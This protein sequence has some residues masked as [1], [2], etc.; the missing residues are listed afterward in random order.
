MTLLSSLQEELAKP[1]TTVQLCLL[2]IIAG[3]CSASLIILFRLGYESIQLHFLSGVGQYA[4]LA[5]KWRFLLPIAGAILIVI[6]AY[7]TGFKHYRLGIPFII[8]RV[9][10]FYGTVPL[11][12]TLNQFFGGMVALA[13]GFSVGREGPSVH[14]GAAGSSFLGT[15]LK[16]PYN[17]VRILA[18][19]G[20]AAG[21]SASFNTPFAAVIFVMEVVLREYRIHM[22]IPV[23]LSAACGSILTRM[24]FGSGHELDFLNV[25]GMQGWTLVYLIPFGMFLGACATFFNVYLMR[26]IKMFRPMTMISRLLLA[27]LITGCVGYLIPDAMGTGLS[28]VNLVVDAPD[29][30]TLLLMVLVAK[31]FL[32]MAAIGLGVPGGIIGPVVGIGVLAGVLLL[33]PLEYFAPG[34]E[35]YTSSFA[36]LGMAAFMTSV[37]HAPLA[38]LSFV[39][40]LSYDT[41]VILPAMLVIVPSFV[42]A[43]QF[44]GNRS[45]FIRQLDYQ[46]LAYTTSS[47]RDAL[48]KV[49]VMALVDKEYKLFVEAPHS[50]ILDFL[51]T[52]PTHPVVQQ[53]TYEIDVSFQLVQYDVSLNPH[54]HTPLAFHD[55]QGVPSQST[56]AEVY[57]ILQAN[58]DGAVYVYRGQAANIV[59]VITW[60]C[61]RQYLNK[62][63]Y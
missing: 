54:D 11:R 22:F 18:G 3:A 35:Q 9:K 43:N 40:E 34:T 63:E 27:G 55:M 4:S 20:I 33:L 28:A 52:A 30:T 1:K 24:V 31:V 25:I 12:T 7:L 2:G 16:L 50:V 47:I 58:R 56:L 49:G 38:A 44:L 23:M 37:L 51:D 10:Q 5:P 15:W 17:A 41:S 36:L 45:I 60:D 48:Q 39:M 46:K 29:E 42:T 26:I 19:C 14:L 61:V 62:Q 13:S 32:T 59:G 57:E 53:S 21:I 8:H 6:F